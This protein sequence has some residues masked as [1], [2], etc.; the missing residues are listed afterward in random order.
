M[1]QYERD[2]EKE[3]KWEVGGGGEIQMMIRLKGDRRMVVHFLW[4]WWNFLQI[5]FNSVAASREYRKLWMEL[6]SFV[7]L[8]LEKA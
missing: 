3:W 6:F 1:N 8:M 7:C 4:D 2:G 5:E